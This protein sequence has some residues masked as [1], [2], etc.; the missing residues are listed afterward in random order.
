[1][2]YLTQYYSTQFLVEVIQTSFRRMLLPSLSS[3]LYLFHRQCERLKNGSEIF[4]NAFDLIKT[5]MTEAADG[6]ATSKQTALHLLAARVV[7]IMNLDLE[8]IEKEIPTRFQRR[9]TYEV[10]NMDPAALGTF[11]LRWCLRVMINYPNPE[12]ILKDSPK[13]DAAEKHAPN[14]D[15]PAAL[16]V[17]TEDVIFNQLLPKCLSDDWKSPAERALLCVDMFELAFVSSKY[18]VCEQVS[19]TLSSAIIKS[20]P[21][22]HA[23]RYLALQSVAQSL[24]GSSSEP[25]SPQM[26]LQDVL[27]HLKGAFDDK[28]KLFDKLLGLLQ[29]DIPANVIG[30]SQRERIVLQGDLLPRQIISKCA[31]I[32]LVTAWFHC[33]GSS[34]VLIAKMKSL[35]TGAFVN[36]TDSKSDFEASLSILASS[37]ERLIDPLRS[38]L[39]ASF[40]EVTV[41]FLRLIAWSAHPLSS[42][43]FGN[44]IEKNGPFE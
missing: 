36:A 11:H 6:A 40:D 5:F 10:A 4:P 26:A 30:F 24:G 7:K 20:L 14:A 13:D 37:M 9:L 31:A 16:P 35:W 32:D 17:V 3:C 18:D 23:E 42:E 38:H 21:E 25:Q 28:N 34:R 39:G 22:T 8:S 12:Q 29:S 1:M 19:K 2:Y 15:A 44:L 33:G 27:N 43:E 41:Y